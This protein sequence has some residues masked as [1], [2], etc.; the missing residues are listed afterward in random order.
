MSFLLPF[1]VAFFLVFAEST[2]DL[3]SFASH[4][5]SVSLEDDD[6]SLLFGTGIFANA[7]CF[8]L[9]LYLFLR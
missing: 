5:E 1:L 3:S 7:P 8:A 4:E 9:S 6:D 2:S